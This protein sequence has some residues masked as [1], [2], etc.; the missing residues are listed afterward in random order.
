M[1]I[2]M[3]DIERMPLMHRVY[4][5]LYNIRPSNMRFIG[6]ICRIVTAITTQTITMTKFADSNNDC[7]KDYAGK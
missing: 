3:I 7:R 2:D 1:M 5:E 6:G 4:H